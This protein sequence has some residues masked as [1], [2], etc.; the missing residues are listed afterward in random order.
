MT[1]QNGV[2]G[3]GSRAI[4][5]VSA[6][7]SYDRAGCVIVPCHGVYRVCPRGVSVGKAGAEP[8]VTPPARSIASSV[9]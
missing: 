3:V 2:S 4:A 5:E 9:V 8:S 7:Q 6:S 1:V